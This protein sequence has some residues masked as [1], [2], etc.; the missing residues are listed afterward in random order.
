MML[1]RLNETIR[2]HLSDNIISY[3]I[4]IF[5]FILGISFGAITVKNID[6]TTKSEVKSYI[7]GFISIT[8]T[9]SIHST[10]ILK[11]SIKFNLLSTGA[12]FI[13]G[14]TYAGILLTPAIAAFRGFCIGFTVAFLTDSLGKGGFLLALVSILPQNIIY[15]PIL[16]IFCVCSIS[17]S[18]AV[19]RN[20]LNRKHGEL[21]SF[22]WSFA[23]SALF[24]FL[25]MMGGSVI[26]S[27]L[28]PYLVKLVAPY[29]M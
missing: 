8:R 26:E 5:F 23:L 9:D 7:D 22:I 28:T 17:L 16:I 6:V 11:Q 1:L 19:L 15:I 27:Y 29:F 13:A 3:A 24:L 10:E 21:S 2:R 4:I 25:I 20:R 14:L 18:L 12:L